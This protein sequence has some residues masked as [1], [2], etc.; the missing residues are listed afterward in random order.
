MRHMLGF[1]V[2]AISVAGLAAC[3]N[4]ISSA[5]SG[6]VHSWHWYQG[7]LATMK[8]MLKRCDKYG[9]AA[10]N[11]PNCMNAFN[12]ETTAVWEPSK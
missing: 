5:H 11:H 3:S 6:P 7:H 4:S 1:I 8:A 12:A 9:E 2:L 10:Q